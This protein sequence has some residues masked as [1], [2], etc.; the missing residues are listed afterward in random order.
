[1]KFTIIARARVYH[2]WTYKITAIYMPNFKLPS[3]LA[4]LTIP[5]HDLID[6]SPPPPLPSDSTR[7]F[8]S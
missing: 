3:L 2:E 6:T 1:M 8:T 4:P 7:L 5:R